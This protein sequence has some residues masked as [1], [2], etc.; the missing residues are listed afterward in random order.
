MDEQWSFVGK[1]SEQRWR[2][3]AW[4]PHFKRVFAYRD[5]KRQG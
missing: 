2:W 5:C 4:S 3:Y 1:K